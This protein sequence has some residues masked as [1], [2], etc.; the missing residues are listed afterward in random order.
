M[1]VQFTPDFAV[2]R[3]SIENTE[4]VMFLQPEEIYFFLEQE[5][6]SSINKEERVKGYK[7]KVKYQPV[8]AEEKKNK[9]EAVGQVLLQ[10]LKRLK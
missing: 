3:L 10:A 4:K 7:V 8:Q 2:D 5:A 1:G 6:A 9:R